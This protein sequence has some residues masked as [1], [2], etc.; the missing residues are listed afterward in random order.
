MKKGFIYGAGT[1]AYQI[2]GAYN[3]DGKGLNIWDVYTERHGMICNGEDGKVACDHYHRFKEDVALMKEL[4]LHAYRFSVSWARI[5]P[6]GT[7]RINQAGIDFYN[8]LIDELVAAGIEPYLTL[9]HW[10]LPLALHERGGLLNRD[11]ADWFAEYAGIAAE[12]FSDRVKHIT[13]FNEPQCV[14]GGYLGESRAPGMNLSLKEAFRAVHHIVLAHGKATDAMRRVGAPDLQIGIAPCG[15][16]ATP[17]TN[18]PE[19]VERARLESLDTLHGKSWFASPTLY[20]DPIM[21]G[22]YS[23][24]IMAQ[25]AEYLPEGWQEDMA[26]IHRP[27]DFYCQNFYQSTLCSAEKGFIQPGSGNPRNSAGWNILPE[28]I[29]WAVRFLYE[30]YRTPII[31]SENGICGHEWVSDDGCVHDPQRI[32]FIRWHLNWLEKAEQDGVDVR[33]YFYWS[34]MDNFEW[35]EGYKERFGLI[36][37]DYQTMQRTVKD[38]GWWYRDTIASNEK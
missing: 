10:D 30:R 5:L 36:F 32:D 23:P 15:F 19:D 17:A 11:F 27:V 20:S 34:F 7:G 4:G 1:A 8:A 22:H 14:M 33:G 3:E 24:A 9:F 35:A 12:H 31:I 29:Y 16:I 28:G 26:Q 6:E 25:Y 2:E 37:I 21:L 13:T 38:S 18:S